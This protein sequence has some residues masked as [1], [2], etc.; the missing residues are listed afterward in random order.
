[1]A[2]GIWN[3]TIV[4]VLLHVKVRKNGTALMKKEFAGAHTI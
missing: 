3:S 1:M 4:R 2:D